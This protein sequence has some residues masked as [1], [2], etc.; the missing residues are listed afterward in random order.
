MVKL[1]GPVTRVAG[2]IPVS[3]SSAKWFGLV[4]LILCFKISILTPPKISHITNILIFFKNSNT[5]FYKLDPKQ[6]YNPHKKKTLK[7]LD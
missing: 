7:K 3:W 2:S 1:L 6:K 5:N 4:A